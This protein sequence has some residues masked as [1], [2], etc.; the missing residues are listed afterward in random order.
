MN[1]RV[2]VCTDKKFPR[3]DAGSNRILNICRA[4]ELCGHKTYVIGHGK[5]GYGEYNGIK[6]YNV[7]CSKNIISRVMRFIFGGKQMI[8]E[9]K[10]NN[11]SKDD[12]C[13][14]YM[15][16]YFSLRTLLN[17]TYKKIGASVATDVVEWH[18][19]Y[20]MGGKN[21]LTYKLYKRMFDKLYPESKKVIPISKCLQV[22]FESVGCETCLIPIFIDPQEHPFEERKSNGYVNLVYAGNPY[23]KEDFECMLKALSSLPDDVRSRFKFHLA[24]VSQETLFSA[25]GPDA[26]IILEILKDNLIR[27]DWLN[28]D[29]LLKLYSKMD[30]LYVAKLENTVNIAGFPSKIP[31]MMASG[32]VPIINRIGDII[33][34]LSDG[35]DSI[36]YENAN[37]EDCRNALL[38]VAK[39]T[40]EDISLMRRSARNTAC[41]AFDYRVWGE[42]ISYFFN[43]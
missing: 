21:S 15:N 6:Y 19:P 22:H 23:L 30:F 3:G 38:K 9:L 12:F 8:A 1:K 20:Q 27:Y 32:V 28:F 36:L 18:Q 5:S 39:L 34:Y 14:F 40:D 11:F 7:K 2:F 37:T 16:S 26:E 13:V 35:V 33:D 25:A 17:Y 42:K 10:K 29:E 4:L 31:E 41:N 43:K 24:G